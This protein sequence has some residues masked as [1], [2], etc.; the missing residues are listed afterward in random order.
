MT[1]N[2][3]DAFKIDLDELFYMHGGD[4]VLPSIED[5]GETWWRY[6]DDDDEG[7]FCLYTYNEGVDDISI[8]DSVVA[9]VTEQFNL[10]PSIFTDVIAD[11][12]AIT[13]DNNYLMRM[14]TSSGEVYT[15]D[16]SYIPDFLFTP[17][18]IEACGFATA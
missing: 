3:A 12:I 8:L 10:F 15:T 7:A 1:A 14:R 16:G 17:D 13:P 18:E 9:E 2:I 6:L 5:G 11:V 4:R